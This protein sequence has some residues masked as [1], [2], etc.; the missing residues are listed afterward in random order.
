MTTQSGALVLCDITNAQSTY[1]TDCTDTSLWNDKFITA[2]SIRLAM[3]ICGTLCKPE[4]AAKLS[5]QLAQMYA[6]ALPGE[7]Y[8][9]EGW[10]SDAKDGE[11]SRLVVYNMA[12]RLV[13]ARMVSSI[14]EDMPEAVQC[15]LYWDRARRSALRDFPYRFAQRRVRLI[16]R[17]M[18][19]GYE[20]EWRHCYSMPSAA[21]KINRVHGGRE[22]VVHDHYNIEHDD[23]GEFILCNISPAYATCAMDIADPAQWDEMFTVVMA[24]KLAS[25]I[26]SALLGENAA[27]KVQELNA[28]YRSSIPE[29]EGD[30]ASEAKESRLDRDAW[31]AA[32]DNW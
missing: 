10:I 4:V 2:L 8:I 17:S 18:P 24:R 29:A 3:S 15:G 11:A 27:Q 26:A 32:R 31:L 14:W 13:G 19:E 12:L 9:E 6:A 16:P 28:L 7:R 21:L 25:M 22:D 1:V 20:N 23:T 5:E 30:D